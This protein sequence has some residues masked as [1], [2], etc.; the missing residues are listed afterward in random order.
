MENNMRYAIDEIIN[1][2]V[3]LED[4]ETGEKNHTTEDATG[5]VVIIKPNSENG[6]NGTNYDWLYD[7]LDSAFALF[8]EGKLQKSEKLPDGFDDFFGD[9]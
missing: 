8:H 5:D 9:D 1:D 7:Y 4:I 6:L 2:I 3:I